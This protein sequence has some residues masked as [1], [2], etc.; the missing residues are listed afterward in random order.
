MILLD[1]DVMI[2]ILRNYAPVIA[3]LKSISS[4]EIALPGF[5]AM[6]LLQGCANKTELTKVQKILQNFEIIWPMPEACAEALN[7]FAEG[8]LSQGLGLLDTLIG[9]T[10]V[11]L[12]VPFHAFNTK[13]YLT[14]P[15]LVT[16][17]PYLK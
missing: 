6:E 13:H 5:V 7:V 17:K 16:V 10:A 2:D 14:I 12:N 11:S 9:Q 1:S 4:E 3:W 8:Y 15:N